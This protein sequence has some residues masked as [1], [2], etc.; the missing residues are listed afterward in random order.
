MGTVYLVGAGPGDPGLLTLRAAE[1]IR[2]ADM[3]VYDARTSE[4]IL[5]L[6]R[7]DAERVCVGGGRSGDGI[8]R[9]VSQEE[10]HRCLADG[11]REHEVIVRLK[12]GDPFVFGR[13]GEEAVALRDALIPFEV[14]P[15]VSAGLAAAT[16]AGVPVTYVGT[17]EVR[18]VGA[19]A[20][21][22][23]GAG[24][25]SPGSAVTTLAYMA[26]GRIAEVVEGLLRDG[27]AS[28]GTPAAVVEWA[29]WP[30]QRVVA[31]PLGELAAKA[32]QAGI[33]KPCVVIAGDVVALRDRLAWLETRPL[34][35]RRVLVTRARAQAADLVDSLESLGA[36]AVQFPTIRIAPPADPEPIH[37]AA[38]DIAFYDWVIFT[39]VNGV[40]RFWHVLEAVGY[41]AR[42]LGG[43]QVAC[44]GPATAAALEMH[45]VRPEVMPHP[46]VAEAMIEALEQ[47]ADLQGARILLPR[48]HGSR[49]LLPEELTRRGALVDDVEAYR[50]V[51]DTVGADAV[52]RRL[53]AGEIDALTFTASSTVRSF[54]EAVGPDIGPA[55]VAVIGPVT[56]ETA[57]QL[58]LRVD[59]T[60]AEHTVP[61]LVRA[62][63][64]W[65][66]GAGVAD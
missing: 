66:R 53:Q 31:A 55:A 47:A 49:E 52:R 48:A 19:G 65:F 22:G 41:D 64:A 46:Y 30:R 15:G 42:A 17:R 28:A 37:A 43:V 1:L 32:E 51:P 2:R 5:E 60:A 3:L 59:V 45:G 54:V 23:A 14:V 8:A 61:G 29:T 9:C 21:A 34:F 33:G 35:G 50:M 6:A 11:A 36:E 20:G 38:Q 16:Y 18:L 63:A 25:A 12:E 62:L 7:P 4:R 44:I 58:G 13:G 24:G 26:D 57:D 10:I 40:E 27:A 56:R 39:S